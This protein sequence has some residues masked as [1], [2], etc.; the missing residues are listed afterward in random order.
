MSRVLCLECVE[1]IWSVEDVEDVEFQLSCS[2]ASPNVL[3]MFG[4]HDRQ[5]KG[6]ARLRATAARRAK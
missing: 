5:K 3:E 6:K 1:S 2:V 4:R